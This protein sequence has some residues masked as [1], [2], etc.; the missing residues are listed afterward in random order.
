[1]RRGPVVLA[2]TALVGTSL[3]AP[4]TAGAASTTTLATSPA[5][6]TCPPGETT[7]VFGLVWKCVT[8][9][10]GTTWAAGGPATSSPSPLGD[11]GRCQAGDWVQ[12]DRERLECTR[13]GRTMTWAGLRRG[14]LVAK[15]DMWIQSRPATLSGSCRT[16]SWLQLTGVKITCAK[17]K[18][19]PT[20]TARPKTRPTQTTTTTPTTSASVPAPEGAAKETCLNAWWDR[21]FAGAI[22]QLAPR[23]DP[24]LTER[25]WS[26]C[27]HNY[28]RYM[29]A[30]ERDAAYA[31]F[32]GQVGQLVA[33]E[34]QKVSASTG[35]NPCKALEAFLKPHYASGYGLIGWD[36]SGFLPI[37]YRQW[38]GGP[39]I[40]KLGGNSDNCASGQV[41]LQLRRH[42][43]GRHEGPYFPALGTADATWPIS[44]DDMQASWVKGAT[45]VVWSRAFGNTSPGSAA[46]VVGYNYTNMGDGVNM[47]A[48][49]NEVTKCE[50]KVAEAAGLPVVW[51]ADASATALRAVPA[52]YAGTWHTMA[53]GCSWTLQPGDGGPTVSWTPAD[54]PYISVALRAGDQFASTCELHQS[55]WEHMIVAPDGL[56]PLQSVSPGPRRPTTPST[57]RYTVTGAPALRNPPGA[58]DLAPYRGETVVFDTTTGQDGLGALLRSVGCGHWDLV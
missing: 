28:A 5:S 50:F 21:E 27:H 55:D 44:E 49:D 48:A 46:L 36:P 42:Y 1:M 20:W 58:S 31:D 11:R 17:V 24:T 30:S 29:T 54:G 47:V 52:N 14:A 3:L 10:G 35:M 39:M 33:G 41:S 4:P 26:F 38:Q 16:S 53:D 7:L 23:Q 19:K 37:L 6:A 9:Q 22:P 34:V 8:S 57:C 18:G 2:V 13:V 51:K 40:G 15:A 56:F 45:C 32:F 12:V 43:N 25:I